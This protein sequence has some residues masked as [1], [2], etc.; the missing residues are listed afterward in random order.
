MS[1]VARAS[2]R[3]RDYT[4]WALVQAEALKLADWFGPF[5]FTICG[6]PSGEGDALLAP[7]YPAQQFGKVLSHA[8]ASTVDIE[9]A[10]ALV[11]APHRHAGLVLKRCLQGGVFTGVVVVPKWTKAAWWPLVRNWQIV[12]EYPAGTQDLFYA[13]PVDA[14]GGSQFMPPADYSFV[15]LRVT[16]GRK[17]Y[18]AYGYGPCLEVPDLKPV[19]DT[20]SL[21]V[22]STSSQVIRLEAKVRGALVSVLVDSGASHDYISTRVVTDL[23]LPTMAGEAMAVRLGDGHHVDASLLVPRLSF[24]V[25]SFKDTRSFRVTQLAGYDIILGKPWL[26]Q[27]NPSINWVDNTIKLQRGSNTFILAPPK[28]ELDEGDSHVAVINATQLKRLLQDGN[29]A[30]LAVLTECEAASDASA[31]PVAQREQGEP[32]TQ[33][34]IPELQ[35]RMKKLLDR[36]GKIFGPLPKCLPPKREVD[37]EIELEPG[38]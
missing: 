1:P 26:T 19:L 21:Y 31:E 25:K 3:L 27:Y 2:S 11:V 10:N 36:F 28:K 38:A 33:R 23:A 35:P 8:Q 4:G 7:D 20:P 30:Y 13:P 14:N 37:H 15:V 32:A 24:R 29:H 18:S 6:P 12:H 22:A 5:K 16:P 9:Q 17:V 34:T